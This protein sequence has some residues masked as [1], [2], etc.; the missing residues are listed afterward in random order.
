MPPVES[1]VIPIYFTQIARK[2]N[3]K[4]FH[5]NGWLHATIQCNSTDRSPFWS[6][7][8]TC[9]VSFGENDS[10]NYSL[11][12]TG[13]KSSLKLKNL[14][15]SAIFE[16]N[17]SD[18][19]KFHVDVYKVVGIWDK[20]T[21]IDF[22]KPNGGVFDAILLV[23]GRRIYVGRQVLRMYSKFFDR[24]FHSSE[25]TQ[26]VLEG[27]KY[28]EIIEFLHFLYPTN[29]EMTSS[30]VERL[31]N[32]SKRFD[33]EIVRNRCENWLISDH[34]GEKSIDFGLKLL[35]AERFELSRL[36]NEILNSLESLEDVRPLA[37]SGFYRKVGGAIKI[38]ILDRILEISRGTEDSDDGETASRCSIGHCED[39]EDVME[40]SED[41][42]DPDDVESYE[43]EYSEDSEAGNDADD[44]SREE[45]SSGN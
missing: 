13:G 24:I 20:S 12:F 32:H 16:E 9:R 18:L 2:K 1:H 25:H 40:D 28:E 21:K 7:S 15:K 44:D 30:N 37:V 41:S 11:H 33:V 29:A 31:L 43:S 26:I 22:T 8:G 36:L 23:E 17:Y 19:I 5:R 14:K 42:E 34:F 3:F 45:K 39:S 10:Q 35:L 38:R 27:G 6:I 4:C